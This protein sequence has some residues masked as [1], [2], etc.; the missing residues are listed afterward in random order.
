METEKKEAI[1][2]LIA[3]VAIYSIFGLFIGLMSSMDKRTQGL[4][5]CRYKS[6]MSYINPGYIG[7]CE[8]TRVRFIK[9]EEDYY[10]LNK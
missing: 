5:G 10:E 4:D 2:V 8:L 1:G 7:I 9:P 3:I 6:Y